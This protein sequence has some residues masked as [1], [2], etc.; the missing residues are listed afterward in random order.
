MLEF[1]L[2]SL[3]REQVLLFI[4]NRGEGYA[5]EISRYFDAS[6]DSVQKQLKRLEKGSVLKCERK[7]RTL[8]YRFNKKYPCLDE[9]CGLLKRVSLINTSDTAENITKEICIR[10]I[11]RTK[12]I[13]VTVKCYR[14]R[15]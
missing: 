3:V 9:L 10:R 6:L 5:R 4:H 12:P 15:E 1:L 14:G 13:R 2:G 11:R 8:I 7:G